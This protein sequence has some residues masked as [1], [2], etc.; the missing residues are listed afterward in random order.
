MVDRLDATTLRV[1]WPASYT[2]APV[3]VYAGPAPDAIDRQN[4]V[5]RS[6]GLARSLTVRG[7]DPAERT[8]FELVPYSGTPSRIVAERRLPLEGTDNFRDLGGYD[9]ADG[10]SVRWGLLYRSNAL[11]DLSR[12]DLDYLTTLGIRLVC[13]FRSETERMR[14][15]DRTPETNPPSVANLSISVLGVDPAEMQTRI[16]TGGISGPEIEQTMQAA[17]RSFVLDF[18]DRYAA[19]FERISHPEELPTILHCT[20]GKDR[21]GFASAMVLLTLGVSKED[22]FE[23]YLRTNS[24][25]ADYNNWIKR[26]VPV[27]SLFRTR[28]DDMAPLLEARRS[29]LEASLE[30]IDERYGSID[31]Y[32]EHGL[33][34]R[35][36]L[37]ERMQEL[38]LR[39]RPLAAG[40]P[41]AV[42]PPLAADRPQREPARAG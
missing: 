27:Y 8:Y 2:L 32:L 21:A 25:R 41:A 20:A 12:R 31:G 14:D 37:R 4:P 36:E 29:Y 19:M 40:P 16:R 5:G 28:A 42:G 13:D 6:L 3:T 33:K 15:P 17:Y 35:P 18:T 38:F 23:D 9:T 11:A 24:Y 1:R 34:I 10:R 39:R 26:L 7:L 30:T 22:V